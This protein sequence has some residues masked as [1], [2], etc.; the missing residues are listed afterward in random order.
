MP[1]VGWCDNCNVPILDACECGL[2]G[3]S[4]RRLSVGKGEVKPVFDI[5]KEW[6]G[7]ILDKSGYKASKFIPDGLCFYNR[8]EIIVDGRKVFRI[9]FDKEKGAWKAARHTP[10][11]LLLLHAYG[12]PVRGRRRSVKRLHGPCGHSGSEGLD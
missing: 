5:E 4:T 7:E 8:G 6:Y 1:S 9:L 12:D 3:S 2:C 10:P 11:R